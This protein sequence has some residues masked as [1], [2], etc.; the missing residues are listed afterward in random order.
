MCIRMVFLSALSFS[1][2]AEYPHWSLGFDQSGRSLEWIRGVNGYQNKSSEA[3]YSQ[4]NVLLGSVAKPIDLEVSI[5]SLG[6]A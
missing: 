2:F 3:G 6:D 5:V 4:S 1:H